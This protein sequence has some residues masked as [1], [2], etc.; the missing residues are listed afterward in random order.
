MPDG[1]DAAHEQRSHE[2]HRKQVRPLFEHAHD[3]LV[4]REEVGNRRG[5][6]RIHAEK[7]PG[8]E[9]RCPQLAGEGHMD[10]VIVV[11]GEVER[12]KI[13]AAE[14]RGPR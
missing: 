11:W 3:T 6:C 5:R 2:H 9:P 1:G 8:H 10:A 14:L 7:L 13:A 4:S 12:C